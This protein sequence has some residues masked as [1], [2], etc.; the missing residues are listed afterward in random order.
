MI[1]TAAPR[2][3]GRCVAALAGAA[4]APALPDHV[5]SNMAAVDHCSRGE[6]DLAIA[7]LERSLAREFSQYEFQ[8]LLAELL[9]RAGR[10]ESYGRKGE[11]GLEI[12]AAL[13]GLARPPDRY[14]PLLVAKL[15]DRLS[16]QYEERVMREDYAEHTRIALAISRLPRAGKA[17]RILDLGCGTGMLAEAVRSAGVDASLVGVDMSEAMLAQARDRGYERLFREDIES[18]LRTDPARG[19]FDV[20]AHASVIPFFG[21]LHVLMQAIA[22]YISGGA[23]LVFSYDVAGAEAVQ[24]NAHGRFRHAPSH[25][26]AC[27]AAAG[28]RIES[29]ESFVARTERGQPVA[30]R[31]AVA[32]RQ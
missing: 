3:L 8:A 12:V 27:L 5:R 25:V 23:R 6:E 20:V 21:D 18:F 22:Q 2:T 11:F 4:T 19:Q 9:V 29:D 10:W 17:L 15:F 31:V 14:H 26:E 16:P 13:E 32:R 28:F 7:C 24:F 1:P 30:A